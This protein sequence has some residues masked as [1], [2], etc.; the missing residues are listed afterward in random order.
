MKGVDSLGSSKM[1]EN[2]RNFTVLSVGLERLGSLSR[3]GFCRGAHL[4]WGVPGVA[5]N[6]RQRR[7]GSNDFEEGHG[8]TNPQRAI[9]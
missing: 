4:L 6:E 2:C 7:A 9:L 1:V 5:E 8:E 3:G